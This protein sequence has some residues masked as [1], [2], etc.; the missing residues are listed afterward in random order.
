MRCGTVSGSGHTP[1]VLYRTQTH[2]CDRC[3]PLAVAR[4][5]YSGPSRS[6]LATAVEIE[7]QLNK[8]YAYNLKKRVHSQA[9]DDSYVDT[10]CARWRCVCGATYVAFIVSTEPCGLCYYCLHLTR[11]QM[12]LDGCIV[13]VKPF[14]PVLPNFQL[15]E[16]SNR[17]GLSP[18][19]SLTRSGTARE[20]LPG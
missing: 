2:K 4:M 15:D 14:M 11:P 7:E 13:S 5:V 19:H 9:T 8:H 1:H 3:T 12:V 20:R 10:G 16:L 18:P 6:Q 17:L